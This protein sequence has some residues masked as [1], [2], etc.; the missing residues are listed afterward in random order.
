MTTAFTGIPHDA[1]VFFDELERDNTRTWWSENK[2]RYAEV[3]R[4]PITALVTELAARFGT[5]HVFRPHRDVRFAVDTS[6]YK[7]HQGAWCE[8]PGGFAYYVHVD[9]DGLFVGAGGYLLDPDQRRRY[10]AAV[11][12][13]AS[14]AALER[15]IRTATRSG[16]ECG[17]ELV[18]TRPRGVPADH[19]RLNLMRHNTITLRHD[20]GS[21]AWLHTGEAFDR[22]RDGWTGLRPFVAWLDEHIGPGARTRR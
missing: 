21:P 5:A 3:V 2:D 15:L 22:V 11:D 4:G 14:G 20:Y 19:P 13:P 17:G 12:S 18:A 6:P 16:Y 9:A 10:R 7:T 1:L 8:S